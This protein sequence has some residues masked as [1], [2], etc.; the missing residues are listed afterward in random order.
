MGSKRNKE[1]RCAEGSHRPLCSMTNFSEQSRGMLRIYGMRRLVGNLCTV[2]IGRHRIHAN[3][4]RFHR[5]KGSTSSH[6]PAMKGKIRD[7]SI[8]NTKDN[9]H[10]DD[11]SSL[12][13][14]G[15]TMLFKWEVMD[16]WIIYFKECVE[17]LKV[18][19]GNEG[20]TDIDLR[21]MGGLW[22]MIA[23][24]SVEAKE[25]FLLST[26]MAPLEERENHK[27]PHSIGVRV[28]SVW[29]KLCVLIIDGVCIMGILKRSLNRK[30][31]MVFSDEYVVFNILRVFNPK[32]KKDWVKELCVS[33]KVNF[34]T[35]QETKMESID[36]FEIKRC[37]GNFA[38]DYVHSAPLV[39][40]KVGILCVWDP[41]AFKKLNSTVSD[42]FVMIQGNWCLMANYFLL[43]RCMP[44]KSCQK[45]KVYGDYLCPT[46]LILD[47]LSELSVGDFMRN[48]FDR[49]NICSRPMLNMGVSSSSEVNDS[50]GLWK[51]ECIPKGCNSSFI[52]LIPKTPEAKMVKD[53]RPISLIGSLYKIIAKILAN[54]LVVVLGDIVNEE[55]L[56]WSFR[57]APKSGVEQDQLTD[58]TTYVEGVVLGVTP[59]RWYDAL[60]VSCEF[61]A[62]STR[63]G[64]DDNRFPEVYY[65]N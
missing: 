3:A 61:S 23:F 7:S 21:Y 49:P 1:D 31:W 15:L 47:R 63:K 36:L 52:A 30:E 19:L 20:F 33:N 5:P 24:D 18:S 28:R 37:W 65:S 59:D 8:G 27:R 51:S 22:V 39:G 32:A 54:R 16:G 44:H 10:R 34:L 46:S 9:G 12:M 14:S 11:V 64:Y 2:W 62:L 26:K 42:Y 58:L 40:N 43:F 29:T 60:M 4:A 25:K 56:T 53:F 17:N 6:Q 38:F 57:R 50:T 41:N 45:R 13:R 48:R 35:L 55:N